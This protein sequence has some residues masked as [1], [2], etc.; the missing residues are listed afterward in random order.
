MGELIPQ[1]VD[2]TLSVELVNNFLCIT[3]HFL[4][5][6]LVYHYVQSMLSTQIATVKDFFDP[7]DCIFVSLWVFLETTL[8]CK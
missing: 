4:M 7:K 1:I 6:R 3:E 8:V 5:S 2:A